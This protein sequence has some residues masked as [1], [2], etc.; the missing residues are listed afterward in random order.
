MTITTI[1]LL[2]LATGA[3]FVLGVALFAAESDRRRVI[4]ANDLDEQAT[5]LGRL[6]SWTERQ[7]LRTATGRRLRRTLD[8]ADV[9][10]TVGTVV[11]ALVVVMVLAW[12]IAESLGGPVLGVLALVGVVLGFRSFL[13]YRI[14]KRRQKFVDQ[15]PELARL[16]ANATQAGL[17]LR[18]ALGVAAQES[19]E[20][21]KSELEQVNR[22]LVVGADLDEVLDRLADRMPSRE[23]Q[24]L[25]NVLA[26]QVRAGGRVVTALRGITEALET[27]REVRRE[28]NTLLAGTKATVVAVAGL[29]ALMLLLVNTFSEGG[30]RTVLED[31]I[32][33]VLFAVCGTV[34]G[35]GLLLVKK[36]GTVEV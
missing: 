8:R 26:I 13:R 17:A 4:Y 29:G 27:R 34:F 22:E 19:V 3:T 24:V 15:L 28:V 35:L 23:V 6:A 33:I 18:A 20:P 1:V 32:G 36:F 21:V 12:L 5:A 7:T 10:W 2:C 31:P 25:V 11:L 9:S 16:L 14:D 30:L